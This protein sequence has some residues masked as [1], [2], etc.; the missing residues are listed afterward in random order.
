LLRCS[1]M[2]GLRRNGTENLHEEWKPSGIR[3]FPSNR[4]GGKVGE[5][6]QAAFT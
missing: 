6:G 4:T 5:S 1:K 3:F 2:R